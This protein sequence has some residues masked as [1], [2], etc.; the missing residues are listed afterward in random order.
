MR[1]VNDGVSEIDSNLIENLIRPS[2]LGKR[3]FCSSDI[4]KPE[5]PRGN[6]HVAG[7]YL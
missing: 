7:S 4:M 3:A 5:N 2:A 1:F 6:L